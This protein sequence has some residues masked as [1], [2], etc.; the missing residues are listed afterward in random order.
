[1]TNKT[2]K[3]DVFEPIHETVIDLHEAGVLDKEMMR[4]FDLACLTK[5]HEFSPEGIKAII[6]G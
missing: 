5:I 1:M 6:T 4:K 2:Y 3:S